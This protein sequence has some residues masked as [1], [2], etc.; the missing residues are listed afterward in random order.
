[1]DKEIQTLLAQNESIASEKELLRASSN[2]QLQEKDQRIS[3]LMVE[4]EEL[5]KEREIDQQRI[6]E[7]DVQLQTLIKDNKQVAEESNDFKIKFETEQLQGRQVNNQ[8]GEL[9]EK[10]EILVAEKK[11]VEERLA[12]KETKYKDEL[13]TRNDLASS[14]SQL[15]TGTNELKSQVEKFKTC[16]LYTS[17]SPRD[18]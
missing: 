18:S 11:L 14:V 6:I 13:K 1:M 2:L 5:R 8:V 12:D 7:M 10:L 4:M 15:I 16:L 9:E 3:D 17:P